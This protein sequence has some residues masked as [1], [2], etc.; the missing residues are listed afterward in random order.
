MLKKIIV[1][2]LITLFAA[3]ALIVGLSVRAA[4]KEPVTLS[5][6]E[7]DGADQQALLDEFITE[8]HKKYPSITV[9]RTHYETEELR[10][11]FVDAAI[12]G[13]GPD[14]VLGPNDNLGVFVPGNLIVPALEVM[15]REFLKGFTQPSL[16]AASFNGQSYMVPDRN[17]NEL[18]L[19]YNKKLVS[20]APKTWDEMI[21]MAAKLRK[22]GKI[23]YAV[24]FNQTEPYFTLPMLG[25]FGGQVFDDPNSSR[26][27]PTLDTPQVRK[28]IQWLD[29]IHRDGQIPAHA[30]YDIASTLFQEGKAAFLINGPWCFVNFIESYNM[31]IGIA[32]IPRVNGKWPMPYFAVKGYS[33]SRIAASDPDRKEACRLFIEY[34][35]SR[36]CQIRMME[37][38]Q[39][40]PTL[41]SALKDKAVTG[42]PLIA[43]Q[44][45]SLGKGTPMPVITQMRAVWDAIKPVQQQVFAGTISPEDAPAI[46][47]KQAEDGIRALGIRQ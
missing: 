24:V 21:G 45:D 18:C 4:A 12:A 3:G 42:D 37:T 14:V 31:D 6:W 38:H 35:T 47:Q 40:L 26:A 8:F 19:I 28:W 34:V 43:G 2:V 17:G 22:E 10:H 39:Q 27:K 16:T 29:A 30:D 11:T 23:Q 44:L 41:I 15:G 5:F 33:V 13:Q 36:E 25:A 32:A 46:M 7:Q 20:S 1:P 9:K